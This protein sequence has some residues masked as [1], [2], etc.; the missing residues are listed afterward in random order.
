LFIGDVGIWSAPTNRSSSITG[1]DSN[2]GWMLSRA[3]G[4][5][6]STQARDAPSLS[7]LLYALQDVQEW[8]VDMPAKRQRRKQRKGEEQ[9]DVVRQMWQDLVNN[10]HR[11]VEKRRRA[12]LVNPPE[13]IDYLRSR[14]VSQKPTR[15]LLGRRRK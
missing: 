8:E 12:G 13:V 1:F 2:L 14:P 7:R 4:E 6:V 3:A 11:D 15:D 9:D 5:L 10:I